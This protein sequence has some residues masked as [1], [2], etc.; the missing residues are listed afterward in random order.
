[1]RIVIVA[2]MLIGLVPASAQRLDSASSRNQVIKLNL[3]TRLLY[4]SAYVMSYERVFSNNQSLGIT[5]GYI[6][7]PGIRSGSKFNVDKE[8]SHAGMTV[9]L[10]YRF[11]LQKENKYG[12]PHG[13]Y[14]GPYANYY[15]FNNSRELS[16]DVSGTTSHAT[17]DSNIRFTNIGFQAG[18]QFVLGDR[19]TIDMVF[20]G[21]SISNYYMD[22]KTTGD[23]SPDMESELV[24][25]ML[26]RFPLLN[27][28]IEGET[29]SSNGKSSRWAA[30]YRY[31]IAVGYKF[32]FRKPK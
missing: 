1:M 6:Q 28:L 16:S 9:G 14:I 19:W 23:F 22:L 8:L 18:Y 27:D 13:I 15:A 24:Q 32:G 25:E 20:F 11:Y 29:I 26:D 21:P 7:F 17:M 31:T 5:L 12:A 10:E 3:T 2:L 4:S 30:G